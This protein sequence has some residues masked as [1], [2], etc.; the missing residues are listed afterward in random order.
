[1]LMMSSEGVRFSSYFVMKVSLKKEQNCSF[2]FFS[3]K[4]DDHVSSKPILRLHNT[5]F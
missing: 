1:M 3:S 4:T 5:S 2:F